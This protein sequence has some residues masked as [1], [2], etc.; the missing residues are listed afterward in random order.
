MVALRKESVDRNRIAGNLRSAGDPSLSA[1]RAWIEIYN[2]SFAISSVY[3]ALR[4]ESVDRNHNT[5]VIFFHLIF[6]ALRKESVDR[7][8][9]E[10]T[11][12]ERL[13]VALRKESVDRNA[14]AALAAAASALSLSARRAWIEMLDLAAGR[15]P[16]G[17]RG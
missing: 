7:N 9:V 15:S 14:S 6:V 1:R 16:Q 3:V 4:K 11:G 8:L 17:E 5:L 12:V 13:S 10:L 2:R